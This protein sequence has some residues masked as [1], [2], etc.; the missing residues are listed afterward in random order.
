MQFSGLHSFVKAG[1]LQLDPL[2]IEFGVHPFWLQ[3]RVIQMTLKIADREK[4]RIINDSC[5][6]VEC[7]RQVLPL[8]MIEIKQ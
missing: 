5:A 3:Q 8:L 1:L 2:T 7:F 6:I 4:A